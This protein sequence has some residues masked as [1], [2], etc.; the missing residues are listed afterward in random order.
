MHKAKGLV[1]LRNKVGTWGRPKFEAKAN[2]WRMHRKA[3]KKLIR[4]EDIT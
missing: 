3:E 1:I 4:N 2:F